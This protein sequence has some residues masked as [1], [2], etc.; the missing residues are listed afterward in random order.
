MAGALF[1]KIDERYGAALIS[2]LIGFVVYLTTDLTNTDG[3]LYLRVADAYLQGGLEASLLLYDH[4]YYSVMIAFIA[5]LFSVETYSAA[6]FLNCVACGVMAWALYDLGF[7]IGGKVTARVSVG[8]FFLH[9]QF[10]EYR[11]FIVRDFWY[12][13]CCL[14]YLN[15]L[16]RFYKT[17][18]YRYLILGVVLLLV[19]AMFRVES[20][21]FLAVPLLT[22]IPLRRHVSVVRETTKYYGV[23]TAV[24]VLTFIVFFVTQGY[25]IGFYF[26]SIEKFVDAGFRIA[27]ELEY[28][29][30]AFNEGLLKNGYLKEYSLAAVVVA[31]LVIVIL[32]AL[33]SLTASYLMLFLLVVPGSGARISRIAVAPIVVMAV[34]YF[35]T[36]LVFTLV[37]R[38]IQGRHV[39]LLTLLFLP[40]LAVY[41]EDWLLYRCRGKN[42]AITGKL[43]FFVFLIV[44]S[45][46]DSFFSFGKKKEYLVESSRWLESTYSSGCR[47]ASTNT[48]VAY[49]S[50]LDVDWKASQRLTVKKLKSIKRG[51]NIDLVAIEADLDEVNSNA[52]VIYLNQ[53]FKKEKEFV[54][55]KKSVI[56]YSSG[57]YGCTLGG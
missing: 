12:W 6:V 27:V 56:V 46:V 25:G 29:Q 41:V 39:L 57:N 35:I 49:F 15:S 31:F 13:A 48:K 22:L 1:G 3:V 47:L 2:C 34:Y 43:I 38:V 11:T 45:F 50:G 28:L 14:G 4:P 19:G 24:C 17:L 8:L 23:F 5:N 18:F 51:H 52:H 26:H 37:T 53:Y 10:N 33:K 54:G 21:L 20:L 9:P 55:A 32:K 30:A 40:V 42:K 36:I 7:L 44:V 16:I